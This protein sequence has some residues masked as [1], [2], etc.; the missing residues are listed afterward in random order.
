MPSNLDQGSLRKTVPALAP[1][2]FFVAAAVNG[3]EE[4][5]TQEMPTEAKMGLKNIGWDTPSPAAQT[6][7]IKEHTGFLRTRNYGSK[8]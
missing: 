6:C 4:S 2:A 1:K 7:S 8:I 5:K 3:A